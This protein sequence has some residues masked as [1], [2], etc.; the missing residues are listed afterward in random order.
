MAASF[1][2]IHA[3]NNINQGVLMGDHAMLVRL[4]AGE[5]IGLDEFTRGWD[6]LT[7]DIIQQGGLFAFTKALERGEAKMPARNTAQHGM[8]MAE[9]ILSRHLVDSP[10]APVQ[11][12]DPVCVRVDGGYSHEFTTA[13]VHAFLE[14]FGPAQRWPTPA[15]FAKRGPSHLRR[16]RGLDGEVLAQDPDST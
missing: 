6:P 12:G 11:A 8:T 13:Q 10:G 1:A 2:P 7:R 9:K 3:R 14:E 16:R 4:Q 15:K 5:S